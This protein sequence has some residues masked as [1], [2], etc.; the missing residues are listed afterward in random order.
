[1]KIP[2]TNLL[3]IIFSVIFENERK[4]NMGY[5]ISIQMFSQ[6][7]WYVSFC[8]FY[9]CKFWMKFCQILLQSF[10]YSWPGSYLRNIQPVGALI[11]INYY[12]YWKKESQW[13]LV[14]FLRAY[15]IKYLNTSPNFGQT[16]CLLLFF[17][18]GAVGVLF[19]HFHQIT[20]I[21]VLERRIR[22]F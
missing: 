19:F 7:V 16:W 11:S 15:N 12:S 6:L 9:Y 14:G 10:D 4:K 20:I 8:W 21:S 1:M 22:R 13:L 2:H 17:R 3:G 18:P 5:Q